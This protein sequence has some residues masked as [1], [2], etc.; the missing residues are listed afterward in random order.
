ME[1]QRTPEPARCVSQPSQQAASES[2]DSVSSA[3]GLLVLAPSGRVLYLNRKA[4]I[5]LAETRF[6]QRRGSPTG[7]V[8][9]LGVISTSIAET[10]DRISRSHLPLQCLPNPVE[11]K[12]LSGCLGPHLHGHGFLFYERTRLHWV[13]AVLMFDRAT[14]R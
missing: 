4:R 9:Q 1:P 7:Q 11:I 8:S 13:R 12:G 2:C 6:L 14:P 5:L 10:C 3:Q